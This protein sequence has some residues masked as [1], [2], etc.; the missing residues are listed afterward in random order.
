MIKIDTKIKGD[1][2]LEM[3]GVHGNKYIQNLSKSACPPSRILHVKSA[4]MHE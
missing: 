3:E 4:S 1:K 2:Y